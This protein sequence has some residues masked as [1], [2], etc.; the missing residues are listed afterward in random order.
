MMHSDPDGLKLGKDYNV[1]SK[2]WVKVCMFFRSGSEN[3]N[4]LLFSARKE[5]VGDH[6]L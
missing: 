1:W 4:G 2:N 6:S 5:S 3:M